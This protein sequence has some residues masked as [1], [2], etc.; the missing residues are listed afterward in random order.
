MIL[1]I[2]GGLPKGDRH[3]AFLTA[4]TLQGA[5]DDR[6]RKQRRRGD[7]ETER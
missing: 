1:G 6:M 5:L 7:P 4:E 2:R 3:C